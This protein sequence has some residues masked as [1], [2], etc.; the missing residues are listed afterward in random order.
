MSSP[1]GVVQD[2]AKRFRIAHLSDLH[3]SADG[4]PKQA[5]QL[6]VVKALLEDIARA[7]SEYPFDVIVF[8]GDLAFD[9]KR[10]SLQQGKELLLDPLR[11]LFPK[12]PIILVPGN[13]DVD[14]TAIDPVED[15]GLADYL[16]DRDKL[17]TRLVDQ[18]N[19]EKARGRLE[20]WDLFHSAWDA[21]IGVTP[22]KPFGHAYRVETDNLA[23]AVGA[24]DS[25]WRSR[26][27]EED[28]GR[29]IVGAD[30]VKEFIK[31]SG[32]ADLVLV[33]F[34]HPPDWL[35][36]FDS[37]PLSA[38]LE[39]GN[40]LV[41]TG[42]DHVADPTLVL[43]TRGGAVYCKAP[44]S[45]DGPRFSNGYATIDIDLDAGKTDISLRRWSH[46]R[47]AFVPD[48]D[49]AAGGHQEFAWPAELIA[50]VVRLSA[51]GALE[52]LA[53]IAQET[54]VLGDHL[55]DA[56]ENVGDYA[57]APRLWP[58]PHKEVFDKSAD[59][60]ARPD[61]VDPV[62]LLSEHNV[63]TV[64]GPRFSGVTTSLLWILEQ[65]FMRIGTHAPGYVSSDSRFSLGRI[66][67]ALKA[68]RDSSGGA[69][70]ILAVDDVSPSDKRALGR[71]IRL[72]KENPD[73]LFLFGCHDD[74][75]EDVTRALKERL[76]ITPGRVFLGPFGRREARALVVRIVG[77]ESSELVQKVLSVIQRQRLPRNPLNLAA[78]VSVIV[79]EPDLT[80]VNESGL[81]QQYVGV[82]LDNP[83]AIDPE[84]LN[85]DY[86]R[87]EHLLERIAREVV[88]G[89]RTRIPRLEIEQLVID[90]FES[91]GQ[92]SAS[93]GKQVES[94]IGR[95]ILSEDGRGVGFRYPALLYLFAA[96]AA[97]TDPE[98]KE[99]IFAN[100]TQY[101]SVV[102][103]IAGV[104]R[105]DVDTLKRAAE[106]AARVRAEAADG[107][108]A[109]QFQLITDEDGWSEIKDLE[110][111]RSLVRARPEPPSEEELDEIFDE[112]IE[113]PD[114]SL[115][116]D[117]PFDSEEPEGALWQLM[118]GY[119]LAAS[120]L[121]NSELV[122]DI[123]LRREVLR[124]LIDGWSVMTVLMAVEEEMFSS[125]S[126]VV[127]SSFG[128]EDDSERQ[129]S[130][131]EY[132]VRLFIVNLMT[133]GLYIEAGSIHQRQ[134][135][136]EL[137]DDADFMAEPSNALF[138]TMLYA[139]LDFPGWV[140]RLRSLIDLHGD[141]PMVFEMV[142]RWGTV[143]YQSGRLPQPQEKEL[144]DFLVDAIAA[145][146][147]I[148]SAAERTARANAVRESLRASRVRSQWEESDAGQIE[149]SDTDGDG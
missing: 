72:V 53:Q 73:T 36:Q 116:D 71:L 147:S 100:P 52:P 32:D 119:G 26:G 66:T 3:A 23:V 16:V 74:A 19:A 86:R 62:A 101:S 90:Y 97:I 69:P 106:E 139:M 129:L 47:E 17:T 107:V 50:P 8:S 94:L 121:Q 29:L 80:A 85:M 145:R 131:I 105:D 149:I 125:L 28:R 67:T 93:A 65:H 87:R 56:G 81:L 130:M 132:V 117:Q 45:Y 102:R 84:G 5:A 2:G 136:G 9:G 6:R 76:S 42:H 1:G 114:E 113:S 51:P 122:D 110:H 37:E 35:A 27:G 48:H 98:F 104:R 91:I 144:E 41:L 127:A 124:E 70:V 24:F 143:E 57:I 78:L 43:T 140:G 30:S 133:I 54:S 40:C 13:H 128:D 89:E 11:G 108:S 83:S 109:D 77:N 99:F 59:K 141:H 46:R 103:H 112:A 33:T 142:R 137:L 88:S 148:D 64:A 134:M 58:V 120:V 20:A 75:D 96:K 21:G 146:M 92:Q 25:A 61:E 4:G 115:Q 126:Q 79:R 12:V 44:C 38:A 31:N 95:R 60:A 14:R 18:N 39:G 49:S 82:L 10:D 138:A 123:A 135:L 68:A 118:E 63:V 55:G 15:A 111:A 7:G 34:H 22:I